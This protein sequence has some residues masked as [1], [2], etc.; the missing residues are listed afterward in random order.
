LYLI[1]IFLSVFFS[2]RKHQNLPKVSITRAQPST[3]E[4]HH[5]HVAPSHCPESCQHMMR[6]HA[7]LAKKVSADSWGW[8]ALIRCNGQ[9]TTTNVDLKNILF[10]RER[11]GQRLTD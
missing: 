4:K 8:C 2:L 11:A 3:N 1:K 5:D 7:A 9:K 10:I 6:N